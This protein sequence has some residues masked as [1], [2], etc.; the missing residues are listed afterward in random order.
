MDAMRIFEGVFSF[1]L[2]LLGLG[3]DECIVGNIVRIRS[4]RS[5]IVPKWDYILWSLWK[6]WLHIPNMIRCSRAVD[7]AGL[8]IRVIS[9]SI[10]YGIWTVSSGYTSTDY[11]QSR[12]RHSALAEINRSYSIALISTLAKRSLARY[13]ASAHRCFSRIGIHARRTTNHRLSM[14]SITKKLGFHV[15]LLPHLM[16][17]IGS[18]LLF[19]GLEILLDSFLAHQ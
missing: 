2:G 9:T 6:I 4:D 12:L 15:T 5:V 13:V 18:C 10:R 8:W 14:A 1:Q 16:L 19:E 7:C 3:W 17:K 11:L